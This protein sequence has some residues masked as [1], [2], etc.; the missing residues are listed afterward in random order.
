MSRRKQVDRMRELFKKAGFDYQT[1]FIKALQEADPQTKLEA[2]VSVAP[3]FM[4]RLRAEPEIEDQSIDITPDEPKQLKS[5][6]NDELLKL[7][8]GKTK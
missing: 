7:V 5:M 8:N 6:T 2:L 3:F 1:E 4:E